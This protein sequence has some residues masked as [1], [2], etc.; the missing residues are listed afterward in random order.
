[1]WKEIYKLRDGHRNSRNIKW[2][3]GQEMGLSENT[4]IY[5]L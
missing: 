2:Y 5:G 1:M 4:E 3:G